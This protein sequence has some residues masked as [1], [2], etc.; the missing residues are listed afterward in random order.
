[1]GEYTG[2]KSTFS[3][4]FL[5]THVDSAVR[6]TSPLELVYTIR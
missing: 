1:M 4:G 2:K 3:S 6:M 5:D